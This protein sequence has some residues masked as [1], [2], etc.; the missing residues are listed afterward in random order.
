MSLQKKRGHSG[1]SDAQPSKY[2]EI[3]IF[4]QCSHGPASPVWKGPRP[5]TRIRRA[6]LHGGTEFKPG[7]QVSTMCLWAGYI[8]SPCLS[9]PI[10]RV[11]REG[12]HVGVAPCNM[13]TI[14]IPRTR[15]QPLVLS[16]SHPESSGFLLYNHTESK[17]S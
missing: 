13:A 14:F 12:Y 3:N 4:F 1:H 7:F 8:T 16:G 11:G 6:D 5:K 2:L 17:G 9:F 15:S 10:C